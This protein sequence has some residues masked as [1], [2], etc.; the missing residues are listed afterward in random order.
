MEGGLS[1]FY[2]VLG[3]PIGPKLEKLASLYTV[4]LQLAKNFSNTEKK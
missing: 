2:R 1:S 4:I 3:R